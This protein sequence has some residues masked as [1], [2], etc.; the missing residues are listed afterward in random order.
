MKIKSLVIIILEILILINL[1]Y[2]YP[3]YYDVLLNYDNEDIDIDFVN[4][5]FLDK[6]IEKNSGEYVMKVLDDNEKTLSEDK[7]DV[8]NIVDY[9][10]IDETGRIVGGG[11]EEFENL[12]FEVYIPYNEKAKEIVIYD[13][14][15]N[16][17]ARKD[18]SMYSKT[19]VMEDFKEKDLGKRES[20]KGIVSFGDKPFNYF[21]IILIVLIIV[22]VVLIIY[23]LRKKGNEI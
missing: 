1:V 15:D 4:I 23:F 16:E 22:L 2:A 20:D 9:D 19:D 17:I 10:E 21:W 14:G 5:I 6:E 18:I 8:F 13:E 7:F 3:F 11:V 12:T